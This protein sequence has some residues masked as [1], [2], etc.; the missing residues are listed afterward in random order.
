[1]WKLWKYLTNNNKQKTNSRPEAAPKTPGGP[2][3]TQYTV[4]DYGDRTVCFVDE[5]RGIHKLLIDKTG[6]IC[7]FPGIIKTDDLKRNVPAK[8]LQPRVRFR[9]SFE[10]RDDRWIMPWEVQPDGAY[11]ADEDG[12]GAEH[13]VEVTLYTYVDQ[14]GDFTGPFRVYEIG[15]RRYAPAESSN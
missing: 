8:Y 6:N 2:H 5:A 10:R 12:F 15:N 3:L 4:Y 13:D 11:W 9:T 1:M 14:N 7:R